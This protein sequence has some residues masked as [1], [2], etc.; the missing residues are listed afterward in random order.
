M[1]KVTKVTVEQVR[2]LVEQEVKKQEVKKKSDVERISK[3]MDS[4]SS[5][6]APLFDSINN[7]VEFEEFLKDSIKLGSK[8]IKSTDILV[9]MTRVAKRL[10]S[11]IE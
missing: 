11:E 9:A 7:I 1:I 3:K 5:Q 6:L 10:R 8:N 4:L 2:R